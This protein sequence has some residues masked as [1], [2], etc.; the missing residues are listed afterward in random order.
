MFFITSQ[1][2][3][4][5]ETENFWYNIRIC[6]K[7]IAQILTNI[8]MTI[9]ACIAHAIHKD[10]DIL[11]AL[12]DIY[13]M[14]LETL[15]QHIDAYIQTLQQSL[16]KTIRS[17]GEPYLKSKDAA[18]LCITCLRAGVTLPPEMLLKMCQTILQLSALDARFIADDNNGTSIYYMKLALA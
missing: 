11:E 12:P 2:L 1:A 14:P 13:E 9:E 7:Q 4:R 5:V 17:L 15:E 10:L 6:T 18:G 16:L 3:E 8:S